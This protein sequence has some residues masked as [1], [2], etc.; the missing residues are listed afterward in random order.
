[1][2]FSGAGKCLCLLIFCVP[3]GELL[4]R[5]S[6]AAHGDS[7][8]ILRAV[9]RCSDAGGVAVADSVRAR[10]GGHERVSGWHRCAPRPGSGLQHA[11]FS[12]ESWPLNHN[13]LF[14]FRDHQ[15]LRLDHS[16][17]RLEFRCDERAT[18]GG[19]AD[20]NPGGAEWISLRG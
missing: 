8:S 17:P 10:G 19:V 20:G 2:W 12:W 5:G 11:L 15:I 16:L 7:V 3:G 6:G 9:L 4:P 18:I 14:P 13:A 1:M